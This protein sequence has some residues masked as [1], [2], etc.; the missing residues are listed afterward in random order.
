MG[1]PALSQSVSNML[2]VQEML[3]L[4]RGKLLISTRRLGMQRFSL[5]QIANAYI[6]VNS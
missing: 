3:I 2:V 4:L 5:F 1:W 6:G